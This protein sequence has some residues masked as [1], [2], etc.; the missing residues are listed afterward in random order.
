MY[1]E[2][3]Q[4]ESQ[5]TETVCISEALKIN[6]EIILKHLQVLVPV[7]CFYKYEAMC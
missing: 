1:K 7:V 2:H 4:K 5:M 6:D 3:S